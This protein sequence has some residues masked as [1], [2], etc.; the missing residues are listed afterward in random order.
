MD[1]AKTLRKLEEMG[2][3]LVAG[4]DY[5]IEDAKMLDDLKELVRR[6]DHEF[7]ETKC[8]RTTSWEVCPECKT[9]A[10]R[11]YNFC[12]ECGRAIKWGGAMK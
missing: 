6:Q 7:T 5:T 12:P 4:D 10:M 9:F 8:S 3:K 1:I 11:N 2:E